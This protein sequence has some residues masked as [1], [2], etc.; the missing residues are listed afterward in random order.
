MR[1]TMMTSAKSANYQAAHSNILE[2]FDTITKGLAMFITMS[3][4]KKSKQALE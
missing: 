4:K 2:P 3:H 1:Y